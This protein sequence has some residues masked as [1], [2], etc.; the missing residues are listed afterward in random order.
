MK[1]IRKAGRSIRRVTLA[2][3]CVLAFCMCVPTS[4]GT[5]T[6]LITSVE[7]AVKLNASKRTLVV[8]QTATL[9]VKGTSAK[10]T[11]SSSNKKVVSVTSK[12]R[13]KGKA[14]G[15]ATITAKVNGKKLKCRVTVKRNYLKFSGNGGRETGF[16]DVSQSG[17]QIPSIRI[18]P[19]SIEYLSDGSLKFQVRL[20]NFSTFNWSRIA[21]LDGVVIQGKKSGRTLV[22]I[23]VLRS[24]SPFSLASG[25]SV[26]LTLTFKGSNVKRLVSLPKEGGIR[27]AIDI[28]RG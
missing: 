4:V 22:D 7:A 21:R 26:T 2:L 18:T 3:V 24:S 28:Y 20:Y 16:Y 1:Y 14:K 15:T 6:G 23:P 17:E 9:K 8:G 27:Y 10:V 12:G 19:L 11:W 25:K 13:I 5:Q